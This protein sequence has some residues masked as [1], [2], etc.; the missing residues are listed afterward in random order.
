VAMDA[1]QLKSIVLNLL[2]N[3]VDALTECAEKRIGVMTELYD[4][5]DGNAYV[6]LTVSDNGPGVPAHL[7]ER[8]FEPFFTTKTSGNGIGLATALKM[9]QECG[10]LL[11][12]SK[13]PEWAGGAEFVLQLPLARSRD[14]L[15]DTRVLTTAG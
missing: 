11:R 13:S 14:E 15:A 6:E 5:G 12:C 8:I 4:S 3:S 7:R 1:R 2:L 10:G 9:V